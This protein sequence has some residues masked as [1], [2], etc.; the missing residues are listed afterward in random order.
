MNEFTIRQA[1]LDDIPFLVDTIIEA[2]KSGTEVFSYST[3]F[4]ISEDDSKKFIADML[5]E[6][7]DGCELSI[8]SFVVAEKSGLV[9]AALSAWI[10]GIN[11]I[12]S[13][14]LK[15]NLLRYTLPE[16][17]FLNAQ[18]ANLI[19][20]DLNMEYFDNSIQIGAG[21]VSKEFRGNRLLA[22][23]TSAIINQLCAVRPTLKDVYAQIFACNLPSIK[24]YERE[25][26]EVVMYKESIRDEILKYLP[27]NRKILMKKELYKNNNR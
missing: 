22:V 19:I 26:F 10:E 21:F 3:I 16:K 4:G 17:C 20:Q 9:A 14:I 15:G 27:S 18:K 6:E 25:G 1:T 8:S 23:L 13:S 7:I 11:G 2:E 5:S 12:P 24:T